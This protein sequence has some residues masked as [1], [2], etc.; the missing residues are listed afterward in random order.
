MVDT[1]ENLFFPSLV[2]SSFYFACQMKERKR[3]KKELEA[4]TTVGIIEKWGGNEVKYLLKKNQK[5]DF[6][7][8]IGNLM[9]LGAYHFPKL[10]LLLLLIIL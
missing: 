2:P 9:A 8:G 7:R 3:E 10:L 5:N 4:A 6:G 1:H